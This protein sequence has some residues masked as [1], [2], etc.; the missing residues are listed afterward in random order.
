MPSTN[1]TTDIDVNALL[2]KIARLEKEK[3]QRASKGKDEPVYVEFTEFTSNKGKDNEKLHNMLTFKGGGLFWK[4]IPLSVK[5][6]RVICENI[7][8]L[9]RALRKYDE[10]TLSVGDTVKKA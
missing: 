6:A 1:T 10:G 5:K 8:L 4:G 2:A 7:A 9:Q 3:G